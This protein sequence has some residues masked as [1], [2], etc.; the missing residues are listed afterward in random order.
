MTRFARPDAEIA[1]ENCVTDAV[2]GHFADLDR[3]MAA[4]ELLSVS[5]ELIE[6]VAFDMAPRIGADAAGDLML[7]SVTI[8]KLSQALRV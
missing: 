3:A 6:R 1:P 7:C 2:I 8:G 4:A 5:A